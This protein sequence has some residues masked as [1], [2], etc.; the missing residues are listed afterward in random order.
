MAARCV[1]DV[2]GYSLKDLFV[3]SEGT[4]GVITEVLLKLLPRPAARR[5]MVATFA[6][7]E[8]AAQAVSDI[9]AA[10][11]VPCTLE[12]L[13]QTTVQC[14]EDFAAV[15]LP[16]DIGALLLVECDGH[17]LV[18]EEE[19]NACEGL[20]RSAGALDV[21]TRRRRVARRSAPHGAAA[22]FSALA[23]VRPTTILEDVTV[24]R[25]RLAEMVGY[26]RQV[27]EQHKLHVACSGIWATAISTRRF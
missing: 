18:V 2:A 6:T 1:K 24:P 8:E 23:R 27:A 11:I 26:I 14:V 15:G 21:E 17:R 25:S 4:L 13:D 7:M 22:A 5:T 12:F 19:A 3:G 10:K 16:T 20:L 9:I